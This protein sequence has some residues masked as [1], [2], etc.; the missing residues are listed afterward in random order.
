M[1]YNPRMGFNEQDYH[2]LKTHQSSGSSGSKPYELVATVKKNTAVKSELT[3]D[4]DNLNDI[5]VLLNVPA[6]GSSVATNELSLQFT[7]NGLDKQVH[8]ISASETTNTTHM[9][10]F[11]NTD[12]IYE[13]S[14]S[15]PAG[16]DMGY[17]QQG[18]TAKTFNAEY[19]VQLGTFTQ[20][21]VTK[22]SLMMYSPESYDGLPVNTTMEVF[23]R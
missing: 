11:K 20:I 13:L 22:I 5:V 4:V 2:L 7:G 18:W 14:Y 21:P 12:G 1:N 19:N 8:N 16:G 23:A 6:L 10:T 9:I 15:T 3:V 17:H